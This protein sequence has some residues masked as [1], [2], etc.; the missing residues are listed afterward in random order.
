MKM[1]MKIIKWILI[2]IALL[3][4]IGGVLIYGYDNKSKNIYVK[5][6]KGRKA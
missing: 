1:G 3:S 2:P 6:K 5:N 4:A